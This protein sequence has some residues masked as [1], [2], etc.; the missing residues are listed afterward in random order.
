M[1]RLS[2]SDAIIPP[3]L[4]P[5]L[6]PVSRV[7]LPQFITIG[8]R[9]VY[10]LWALSTVASGGLDWTTKQIGQVRRGNAIL[11]LRSVRWSAYAIIVGVH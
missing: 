8:S 3:H 11:I 10:P 4:S 6:P 2:K 5:T 7:G 9:E 1:W